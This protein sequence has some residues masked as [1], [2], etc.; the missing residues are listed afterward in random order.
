MKTKCVVPA[1]YE[2]KHVYFGVD[3]RAKRSMLLAGIF[4]DATT[5]KPLIIIDK[6]KIILQEK[7]HITMKSFTIWVDE[8]LFPAIQRRREVYGYNGSCI[9]TMDGCTAH[10][11]TYFFEQCKIHNIV[12][13]F[14]APH[15]SDQCQMLDLV[16][17]SAQKRFMK[18]VHGSDI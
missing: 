15:S 7:N 3:R 9:L 4:R 8:V 1:E 2:R 14:L 13:I 5:L 16:I 10:E 18:R 6:V 12:L 11:C 17:F